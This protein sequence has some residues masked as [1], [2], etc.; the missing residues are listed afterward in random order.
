MNFTKNII[1]DNRIKFDFTKNSFDASNILDCENMVLS[2]NG[3]KTR[4][5][6]S[7]FKNKPIFELSEFSEYADFNLTDFYVTVD[8]R[9]AQL[10]VIIESDNDS[11]VHYC[12]LAIFPDGSS[13]SL[14]HIPFNRASA[15]TFAT[16]YS[17][18]IYSGKK[19]VGGGI[20][21]LTRTMSNGV[22]DAFQIYEIS[23]TLDSWTLLS[24]SEFYIPTILSHGR[25]D[26]ANVA[27]TLADINL[28]KP[29]K[30]QS[31][32]LLTGNFK[33]Y[34][35]SD[36]Y[37]SSFTLPEFEGTPDSITCS[38]T[39]DI[40][41]VIQWKMRAENY[42][43]TDKDIG[44]DPITAIY[45]PE[46][47]QVIFINLDGSPYA[48]SFYGL[49][50]NMCF[51]IVNSENS[52]SRVSS[53]TK[54]CNVTGNGKSGTANVTIF[55]GS[56]SNANEII[57]IDPLYPLYFPSNCS[58]SLSSSKGDSESMIVVNESVVF[59]KNKSVS[60]FKVT[61][62]EPYSIENIIHGIE[63]SEKIS[64][65]TLVSE[66]RVS[67]TENINTSSIKRS[68]NE[69]W[70]CG[71]SGNI[72]R[73]DSSLSLKSYNVTL[74]SSPETALISNGYYIAVNGNLC[75]VV[76]IS[77]NSDPKVFTWR[78]PIKILSSSD[79]TTDTVFFAKDQNDSVFIYR[80]SG[81]YDQYF[82]DGAKIVT[83]K[84]SSALSLELFNGMEKK[85]LYDI[86]VNIALTES[87]LMEI[88]DRDKKIGH[89]IV[90]NGKN[91][92]KRPTLFEN[93]AVKFSFGNS[94]LVKEINIRYSDLKKTRR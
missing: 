40:G 36:S 91:L 77:Q 65:P 4:P 90:Y 69:I 60:S 13:R 43:I 24:E 68:G 75:S 74:S 21:F 86:A 1:N 83:E 22:L 76:D 55:S 73:T 59:L 89:H 70:F 49:E 3:F 92:N 84:I 53:M 45:K 7:P 52:A 94:A 17:Y 72:Y 5:G 16:P 38:L 34:Y 11:Y 42:Y 39:T 58:R 80:L 71:E 51:S 62:A 8:E 48:P 88:F 35:T 33:C 79:F 18:V 31:M 2:D 23:E 14:G 10:A 64:Y 6:I 28:P 54:S 30:L 20:Y 81:E 67:L 78:L 44:G 37:S 9:T 56:Y 57:W 27:I 87:S 29:K 41:T 12:I 50:N 26:R 82:V 66:K 63:N 15:D 85:R 93:L 47:N 25:G 19:T 61:S 32:N 46:L